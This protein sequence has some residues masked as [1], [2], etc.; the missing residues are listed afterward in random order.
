MSRSG[1]KF[2]SIKDLLA[3]SGSSSPILERAGLSLSAVKLFVL[4]DKDDK[5][6]SDF[7]NNEK[8]MS[9]IRLL[10]DAGRLMR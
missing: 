9:L 4:R 3:S 1:K 8:V 5:L 10:F 7:D 6:E 2:R